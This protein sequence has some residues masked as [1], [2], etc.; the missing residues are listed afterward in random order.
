MDHQ[1]KPVNLRLG[2][3][4]G[5]NTELLSGE[6]QQNMEVVTSVTGLGA[7]RTQPAA[8][9]GNPLMPG[10]RGPGGGFG[11]L[12]EAAAA[13]PHAHVHGP[14]QDC[15]PGF[16]GLEGDDYGQTVNL[17]ARIADYA[18]PGEVLEARRWPTPLTK[19][20]SRS[21]T[22]ARWSSRASPLPAPPSG[23]PRL[24]GPTRGTS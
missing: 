22:S 7:T 15:A 23:P 20:G 10:G 14:H 17:S 19:R 21:T 9:A 24:R 13:E 12:E 18:R 8:G 11:D 2:I 16:A 3:T 1:L 5:T 6:L 4:D